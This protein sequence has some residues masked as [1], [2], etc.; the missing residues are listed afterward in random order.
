MNAHKTVLS[1]RHFLGTVGVAAAAFAT[2]KTVVFGSSA[3]K[4]TMSHR[5]RI[6]KALTLEETD[7]L[8]FGF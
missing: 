7:R 2:T 8:P 5:E 1:R 4:R 3:A 6:E